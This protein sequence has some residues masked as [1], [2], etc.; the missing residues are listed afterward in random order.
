MITFQPQGGGNNYSDPSYDLP[1]FVEL[2]TR[3]S[4][5]NKDK[6]EKALKGTRDHIY[7]SSNTSSGLFTDYSNFD[8]TPYGSQGS[9]SSRYMYDAMR[10]A[11]NFGMDYYLF[12]ADAER[13]IE[14]AR[15][16][17]THFENDGY[18]HGRFEWN[19]TPV[20]GD[21]YTLGE[22]GANAVACYALVGDPSYEKA[23]KNNLNKAWNGT[24]MTGQWRYYDGLV[25]YLAM[26]H[27]CGSFKIWKPKPTIE[28][29]EVT[30]NEYNGKT[31]TEETTFD[32]F[33]NCKLY[34]V[35]IKPSNSVNVDDIESSNAVVLVPNP[36]EN[37]FTVKSA[38]EITSIEMFNITG[39]KVLNQDNDST[40]EINLPAGSYIVKITT[41]DGNVSVQRLIVK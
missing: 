1:A 8:G 39:Q 21:G 24:L 9:N 12:G 36:A 27:L 16:I 30:E 3:W 18:Q 32:S 28:T 38:K 11:M 5:T 6:W 14:M 17:I 20:Q 23:I 31:Y 26:L 4:D 40:V 35:T 37:Y 19:G 15:R 13:D 34:R 29:K 2:F 33:E 7:K 41:A 22:S 10:C 25:H